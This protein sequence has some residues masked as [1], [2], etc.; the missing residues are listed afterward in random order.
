VT[1]EIKKRRSHLRWA[2]FFVLLLGIGY[3]GFQ[4]TTHPNTPLPNGWNPIAPLRVKDDITL[5]TMWKLER[6][7]RTPD[8]CYTALEEVAQTVRLPDFKENESCTILDQVELRRV[9]DADVKPFKTRCQVALR[10]AMWERDGIQP[11]AIK[12]F[13]SPIGQI[14][15]YSSYS[16]REMR[17]SNGSTGRMSTHAAAEAIDISGF[18][19]EDGQQITLKSGW[20]GTERE[21]AFL[22][23]V[24]DSA[25]KWFKLTLSPDYNS[26]HADHFHLQH[27]GWGSCR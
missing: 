13:E 3:G 18:I 12:H 17:T 10:L 24:R 7:L 20:N 15:H 16:C 26:L 5:L 23:D 25:C 22:R 11:A 8:L 27:E 14:E 4:I 2:A 19:L 9:G 21:A 6:T 1:Y